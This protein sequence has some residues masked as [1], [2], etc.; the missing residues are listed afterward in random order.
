MGNVEI[1]YCLG[2]DIEVVVEGDEIFEVGFLFDLNNNE[3]KKK[4]RIGDFQNGFWNFNDF[5]N[6]ILDNN[7]NFMFILDEMMWDV[8]V[9]V[10]DSEGDMVFS[11][12]NFENV[13]EILSDILDVGD[14]IV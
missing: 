11:G 8:N 13:L 1:I 5:Y 9:M 12:F 6:L 4:G 7:S 2:I 10:L 3:Y 14:Y